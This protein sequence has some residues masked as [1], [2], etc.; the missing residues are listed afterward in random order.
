[1]M[2]PIT[3]AKGKQMLE[4]MQ[5]LYRLKKQA[6]VT[7]ESEALTKGCTDFISRSVVQHADELIACWAAV[8]FEYEPLINAIGGP[9][10]RLAMMQQMQQA[11]QAQTIVKKQDPIS[12][13]EEVSA[14]SAAAQSATPDNIIKL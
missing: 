3:E 9:L 8:H 14:T 7:P 10:R 2:E 5:T 4:A 13:A 11:Q 1:M 6:I 12:A